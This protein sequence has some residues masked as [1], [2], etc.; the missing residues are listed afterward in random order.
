MP[1]FGECRSC[2][3][4]G[5]E[6]RKAVLVS[7]IQESEVKRALLHDLLRP[8]VS[9]P[10]TMIKKILAASILL[11]LAGVPAQA[12]S[13]DRCPAGARLSYAS[14]KYIAEYDVYLDE[15]GYQVV[16][17]SNEDGVNFYIVQKIQDGETAYRVLNGDYIRKPG[18]QITESYRGKVPITYG[19]SHINVS[20][21]YMFQKDNEKRKLEID[22]SDIFASPEN[23]KLINEF[24]NKKAKE[25]WLDALPKEY[26][27][28]S[29]DAKQELARKH[30][31]D[32]VGELGKFSNESRR[33]AFIDAAIKDNRLI[34]PTEYVLN[35]Y[36]LDKALSETEAGSQLAQAAKNRDDMLG[37][38]DGSLYLRYKVY[39]ASDSVL[40]AV[41]DAVLSILADTMIPVNEKLSFIYSLSKNIRSL[42]ELSE[43]AAKNA[44]SLI[45]GDPQKDTAAGLAEYS[46]LS[47]TEKLAYNKELLSINEAIINKEYAALPNSIKRS[48]YKAL[49]DIDK[50]KYA[51]KRSSKNFVNK[52]IYEKNPLNLVLKYKKK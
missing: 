11:S 45:T 38:I 29:D 49:S 15:D 5:F 14:V 4:K 13:L 51:P 7:Y 25:G 33:K 2:F 39:L 42:S 31:R 52:N 47:D 18:S 12:A 22:I 43:A 26:V 50:Y 1:P 28:L 48:Q 37:E 8:G 40:Q 6:C 3:D 41:P 9:C 44:A 10:H 34:K 17:C 36:T 35:Q 30:C 27:R 21:V 16:P 46:K 19:S 24:F 32:I 23:T 20:D